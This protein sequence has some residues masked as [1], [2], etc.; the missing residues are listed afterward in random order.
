M[1]EFVSIAL[2]EKIGRMVNSP[3]L[4]NPTASASIRF[5]LL[6]T[7]ALA[8]ASVLRAG[9]AI[10]FSREKGQ[11]NTAPK[12]T[13]RLPKESQNTL[14]G[15][16][17]RNPFQVAPSISPLNK[18]S[19]AREDRRKRNADLEKKNWMVYD[20]GELQEKDDEEGAFGIH[21][22]SI[23]KDDGTEGSI[24][25]RKDDDGN[26]TGRPRMS[27][28]LTRLP[29]RNRNQPAP[30]K[31]AEAPRS[32]ASRTTLGFSKTGGKDGPVAGDHVSKDLDL[33]G[34]ADVE[35]SSKLSPDERSKAS[36]KE[37]GQGAFGGQMREDRNRPR[38]DF[39]GN[40]PGA[41]AN[42]YKPFGGGE[43]LGSKSGF[44]PGAASASPS[45][46]SPSFNNNP[47]R[48]VGGSSLN[49]GTPDLGFGRAASASSLTAPSLS[50]PFA[51]RSGQPSSGGLQSPYAQPTRPQT[52]ARATYNTFD[53]PRR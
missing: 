42:S 41:S 13:S 50:D 23:E 15:I 6:V 48:S 49:P 52:P 28:T 14:D 22:S 51:N 12:T 26:N 29:G 2:V 34:A 37:L 9:E 10:Q 27:T 33:Q 5:A 31:A 25:A 11:P 19:D 35:K 8:G 16:Q 30:A 17:F 38:S 45:L 4:M 39:N 7:F 47:S 3:R 18:P 46:S 53:V 21:D 20:Q 44:S 1:D 32:E 24:F 40:A 36:L 43:S